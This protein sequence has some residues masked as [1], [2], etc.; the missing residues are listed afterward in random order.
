MRLQRVRY[1]LAAQQQQQGGETNWNEIRCPKSPN[2]TL[3]QNIPKVQSLKIGK[4]VLYINTLLIYPTL[5]TRAGQ[6]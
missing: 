2:H 4:S 6:D 1:N 5:F 3:Q